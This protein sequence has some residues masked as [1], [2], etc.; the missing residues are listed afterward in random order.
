MW[1]GVSTFSE[2]RIK[3]SQILGAKLFGTILFNLSDH[4]FHLVI[5]K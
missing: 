1:D 3:L 4:L 2:R 5:I